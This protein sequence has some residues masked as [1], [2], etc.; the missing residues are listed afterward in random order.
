MGELVRGTRQGVL[1]QNELQLGEV[2]ENR[3]L[4]NM[5]S[6]LGRFKRH[7]EIKL[8]KGVTYRTGDYLAV[9][10]TNPPQ[11]VERALRRFTFA[12]DDRMVIRS[13]GLTSLPTG[14]PV[15]V[16]DLLANYVELAQPA[17]Q[18][19]VEAL[20][21]ATRCPPEKHELEAL[22]K[23]YDAEVLAKRVS[24]L[25]LLERFQACELTFADF[26][27]MLPPLRARQYSI[28]SS[29]LWK[30]DHCTLT[31]SVLDAPAASGQG[32]YVGVASS[33]LAHAEPGTRIPVAVRPP[34]VAFHPPASPETPIIM[35]CAGTGI[36]PFHGFLQ[37]RALQKEHG[38]AVGPAL[39]F[40]GCDAPDMDFLYQEELKAW[41]AEGVVRVYPAFSH[42]P[43][44]E[45]KYVQDRLWQDR[46][47]VEQLFRQNAHIYVCG[48]GKRMAP[49]VR[50]TFVRIY[51]EAA[52]VSFE[53]ANS[54][55]DE[56]E[57]TSTRYVADVFA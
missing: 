45:A 43:E 57:R 4:V 28:S 24:V 39:L 20:A 16:G 33:F 48:D 27:A 19:Q 9:L 52:R 21:D 13:S 17:T 3:E 2:V 42:Q 54:W 49:A 56:L 36:A 14:Y 51:Q 30:A 5:A 31:F 6:P 37:E 7:V 25:E 11:N 35:A 50:E 15:S 22:A 46:K 53:A 12:V 47:E 38:Q 41:E 10:P 34:N 26:L 44:A 55:A 32:R 8:P 1:R 23:D 40:F 29:P 18:K